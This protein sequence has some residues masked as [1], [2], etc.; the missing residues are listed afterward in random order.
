MNQLERL[1]N[2]LVERFPD[3]PTDIDAPAYD[4]G[5]WFLDIQRPGRL[6]R[7]LSNGGPTAVLEYPRQTATTTG[8]GPMKSTRI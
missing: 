4:K 8:P 7:L 5:S 3:L 6:C 1:R 2:D